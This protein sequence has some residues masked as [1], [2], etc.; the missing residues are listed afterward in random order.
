MDFIIIA[1]DKLKI[2]LN[3]EEM[4]EYN[5]EP[6]EMDYSQTST[7][8]VIWSI[9]NKAR[10]ETG[11]NTDS[12]KLTIQIYTSRDGGCEIFVTKENTNIRIESERHTGNNCDVKTIVI[13][14]DFDSL[15]KLCIR[16][17][18][19]KHIKHS[20]LYLSPEGQYC[21]IINMCQRKPSYY[22]IKAENDS[23]FP[24]YISEYGD[25]KICDYFMLYFIKEHYKVI[26]E[27][28]A[29]ENICKM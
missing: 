10:N 2:I 29:V 14:T 8:N 28:E 22:S 6:D 4:I 25:A 12:S 1:H 19:D 3:R 23:I 16:I 18:N 26:S 17:I 13:H 9:L 11:F 27:T 24:E 5:V 15:K 20:S 7:K 21:L